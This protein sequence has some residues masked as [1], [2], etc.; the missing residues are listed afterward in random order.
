[1]INCLEMSVPCPECGGD[2]W[3]KL[4][5]IRRESG[6]YGLYTQVCIDCGWQ[7][8]TED[9]MVENFNAELSDCSHGYC[10]GWDCPN[11]CGDE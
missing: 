8:E 10:L 6:N 11:G 2:T 3:R 7:A 4:F 9:E 5:L 1:M